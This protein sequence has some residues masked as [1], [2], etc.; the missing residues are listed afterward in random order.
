[1]QGGIGLRDI[2]DKGRLRS[3]IRPAYAKANGM[4]LKAKGFR[5]SF[6]R[7]RAYIYLAALQANSAEETAR[8]GSKRLRTKNMLEVHS[9][10]N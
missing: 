5:A 3:W 1:M 2:I 7:T 9:E 4:K 6:V 10:S 8:L